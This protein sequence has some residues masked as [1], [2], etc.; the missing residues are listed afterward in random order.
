MRATGVARTAIIRAEITAPLACPVMLM[1]PIT[2]MWAPTI[3]LTSRNIT[4]PTLTRTLD[5]I[6]TLVTGRILTQAAGTFAGI[7]AGTFAGIIAGITA[8]CI[9]ANTVAI[10]AAASVLVDR[11]R[12]ASFPP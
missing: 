12:G 5:R 9:A 6:L 2:V 8:G 10:I 1:G 3:N 11:H 7:I 4:G